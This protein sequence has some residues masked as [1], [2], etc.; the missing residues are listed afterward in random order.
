MAKAGAIS[1]H[2][3]VE[4]DIELGFNVSIKQQLQLNI[5]LPK[6]HDKNQ[7]ISAKRCMVVL[8]GGGK[9]VILE[10]NDRESF[11][12][13]YCFRKVN[14]EYTVGI[15]SAIV[16]DISKIMQKMFTLD[17][18]SERLVNEILQTG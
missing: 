13:V 12:Y 15:G 7:L 8:L 4:F 6:L 2:D 1:K 11:A 5:G 9:K 18:D 14:P 3:H 16:A 17:F 10:V